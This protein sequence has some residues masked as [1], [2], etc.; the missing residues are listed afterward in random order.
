MLLAVAVV[1]T[2]A[3]CNQ[4]DPSEYTASAKSLYLTGDAKSAIIE[5]KN[6]LQQDA[7]F[8]PARLGLAEVYVDQ[9]RFDDAIKELKV[10]QDLLPE[11]D[12]LHSNVNLL[13]ARAFHMGGQGYRVKSELPEADTRLEISYYRFHEASISG[14]LDSAASIY[15][16]LSEEELSSSFGYL[17]QAERFLFVDDDAESA[18]ELLEQNIEITDPAYGSWML[19]KADVEF[20]LGDAESSLDTLA[21]YTQANPNDLERRFQLANVRVRSGKPLEAK[22]DVRMLLKKVPGNAMLNE[23]DSVIRYAEKDFE[24]SLSAAQLAITQMPEN[25]T[26]RLMA[27]YSAAM[28]EKPD[29]ALENLT[30]IIEKL[31][32]NHPAQRLYIQLSIRSGNGED[33]SDRLMSLDDLSEKDIGLLSSVGL[34]AV[35]NGD[36]DTAKELV[37]KAQELTTGEADTA[38]GMLQLSLNDESGIETLESAFETSNDWMAGSSLASAYLATGKYEAALELA[39]KFRENGKSA[40][41]NMLTGVV[42]AREGSYKDALSYFDL[43]LVDAPENKLAKAAIIE[44]LVGDQQI[45]E[46]KSKL[47]EWILADNDPVYI[48]H[49]IAAMRSAEKLSQAVDYALSLLDS[50]KD[51]VNTPEFNFIVGQSAM[52]DGRSE[53]AVNLLKPHEDELKEKKGYWLVLSTAQNDLGDKDAAF[54]SYQSWMEQEQKNPMPLVGVLRHYA[55]NKQYEKAL[56]VLSVQSDNFEDKTPINMLRIT[57]L[58]SS[59]KVNEASR[60]FDT[61]PL[62]IQ[63]SESGRSLKADIAFAFNEPEKVVELLSDLYPKSKSEAHLKK[64]FISLKKLGK[65]ADAVLLLETHLKSHQESAFASYF[66]GNEKLAIGEIASSVVL[67]ETALKGNATNPMLLNNLAY[68]KWKLGSYSDA[69][70]YATKALEILPNRPEIVDTLA[71]A[72]IDN[73]EPQKAVSLMEDTLSVSDKVIPNDNFTYTYI[74]ALFLTGAVAKAKTVYSE[75]VWL[76]EETDSLANKLL[77]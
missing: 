56:H 54:L 1:A 13:L 62:E 6:A 52:L 74:K 4:K 12:E 20:S 14:D 34:N 61:L 31:P 59:K 67:F 35:K 50:H 55:L 77:N 69:I 71:N 42:L 2:L 49:Y 72:L 19:L 26:S 30:V 75:H 33:I 32:S 64:L 41:G 40:E 58:M 65:N 8:S 68:A 38:L 25:I 3:G 7:N 29:V 39:D 10:V 43:V 37:K 57:F 51:S 28:L 66:L 45:D 15:D 48:R 73:G 27:S 53:T 11:N 76:N 16:A 18:R 46:A 70:K 24:G 5:Y 60:L 44:S 23:L 47:E 63:N 22:D 21:K 36:V 9:R 17:C